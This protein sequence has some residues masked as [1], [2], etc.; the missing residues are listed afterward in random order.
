MPQLTHSNSEQVQRERT[1]AAA[2]GHGLDFVM[3]DR[4]VN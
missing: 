3:M 4:P 2:G 1:V